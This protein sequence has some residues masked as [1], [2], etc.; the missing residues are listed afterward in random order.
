M[1]RRIVVTSGKGGVGKTTFVS[2]LGVQLSRMGCKVLLIDMDFGLNNLDVL[3]GVENKIVYD[4]IDVIEGKCNP[5]QALIEDFYESN[6]F[7]LPSTH[8]FCSKKFG[9]RELL[10]II[11]KIEN[12]FDFILIDCPAGMDGG[13]NRAVECGGEHIVIT[14]PHLSAL[15]DGSKVIS[16]LTEISENVPY[17]VINRARGD[18]MLTGD[19]IS[20]DKINECLNGKLLGVLPEDDEVSKQLLFGGRLPES[21][22]SSMSIK[23]ICENLLYGGDKIYDCTK[24][25]RGIW[26]SIK[27]NLRKMV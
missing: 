7:I 22:E 13:F 23:I 11:S 9:S 14:T 17:L 2:F 21:S 24:K 5:R 18:M 25:Y 15:R 12:D 1:T 20:V 16:K 8:G 4:V 19:M 10:E 3:M 6:L 27:K 26:G